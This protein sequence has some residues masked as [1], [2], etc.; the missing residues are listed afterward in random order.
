V[1]SLLRPQDSNLD[2]TAPKAVVLPLHQGGMARR[3]PIVCQRSDNGV[4]TPPEDDVDRIVRAW[5]RERPD[6]DISPL[7][8]LS[9]VTRIAKQVDKFRREAFR[10]SGLE[11]WEFDVLAALRRA[12]TPYQLSPTA[13]MAETLV[14][15]GAMTHRL[16][17][18]ETRGFIQRSPDPEDGRGVVVQLTKTGGRAVD[19]AFSHLVQAEHLLLSALSPRQRSEAAAALRQLSNDVAGR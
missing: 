3:P 4:V 18:L 15:S 16:T 12:G 9:R 10:A 8:V 5:A 14:S 6:L 2:L 13:L 7:E 1:V 19:T 17:K 11:S